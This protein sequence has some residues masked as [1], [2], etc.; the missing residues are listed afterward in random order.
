MVPDLG[1]LI[2]PEKSYQRLG[3]TE[4]TT[5]WTAVV[6]RSAVTALVLGTV[7]SLISTGTATLVTVASAMLYW[8]I[9]PL[10][11]VAAAVLLVLSAPKRRVNVARGVE[12]MLVGHLPWTLFLL[13]VTV[14][15]IKYP[16]VTLIMMAGALIASVWR[17]VIVT[18]LCRAVLGV[19]RRSAIARAILH[20]SSLLAII[21]VYASWAVALTARL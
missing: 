9:V 6:Q 3:A 1:V 13:G 7:I 16:G 10:V 15:L 2:A 14:L 11:Q 21:F 8:S 12:L 19:D 5:G 4:G 18:A 20:Q 17:A